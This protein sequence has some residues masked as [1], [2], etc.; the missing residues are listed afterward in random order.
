MTDPSGLAPTRMSADIPGIFDELRRALM[1]YY[2]TPFGVDDVSI[3]KERRSL[4]DTDGGAWRQPL[5]EL[6][7]QYASS[8]VSVEESFRAASAHPQA[9]AFA[10]FALPDGVD[11]LYWH[12]H[13]ALLAAC[14]EGRDFVVTAGTGAGKTEAF[15]LPVIADL[16][17][18]S[19]R[20]TG[21][22]RPAPTW[23]RG[24]GEYMPSRE[25][26]IGHRSAV[27]ALVLYPTNALAD[28]QLVRLRRALD[29]DPARAWLD[30][31]RA[32]HRFYFGR[33]TGATPVPGNR[34]SYPA[35]S[36][37][38][39]YMQALDARQRRAGADAHEFIPRIGGA[40][41]HARWDMQAAAPDILVTNYSMLNIMLLRPQEAPIFES[42]RRWLHST[43]GARF[44]L[45]LD[46][47][48]MYRGTAGTEVAYLLRNLRHRLGLDDAPEKFR[49]L[50]A[51]ASLVGGR[52]DDFLE[53]FFALPR[54]RHK[55]I[56]GSL[57]L[58]AVRPTDL[59]TQAPALARAAESALSAGE[60]GAL[61]SETGAADALALALAPDGKPRAVAM[62]ELAAALFPRL[63]DADAQGKALRG[64]LRALGMAD[65]PALPKLRA[66][67]FFRNIDGIWACSDPECQDVPGGRDPRRRVGRLFREP[68]SRCTCGA[69]VLELLHCQNCGDLMLGG[70]TTPSATEKKRF[71]GA[72]HTDFPDFDLLPEEIS[73]TAN[74]GNY[75]VYWPRQ[76]ALGLNSRDWT[77]SESNNG[78]GVT[79]EFRESRYQPGTGRLAN[80]KAHYTGWSFHVVPDMKDGKP[81]VDLRGLRPFPTRCPACGDDWELKR[82]RDGKWIGLEDP[83]R[84][85][86]APVRR[87]RTGF[88][89]INQVLTTEVLG[90]MPDGGRKIIAFSDS[91]DDASELASGLALRH[92][93]DLLRLLTAQ[94]VTE[95]G[96]PYADLQLVKAFY[97]RDAVD[98]DE[99][100]E[101]VRRLRGRHPREF[102][103][104]K[105]IL[106]DDI[107]A[108]PEKQP[109]LEAVIGNLPS[110]KDLQYDMRGLLLD[111][112]TNPGGPAASLQERGGIAWTSLFNWAG[113]RTIKAGL[114][115]E[116]DE[117]LARIEENLGWEFLNGLF[118]SAGRDFESL[119]LGWLSLVGDRG[120]LDLPTG[121]DEAR[122]RCSLRILGHMRRFSGVRAASEKPPAPLFRYWKHI[123]DRDGLDVDVIA[124]R[125]LAAWG[126][127]VVQYTIDPAKVALRPGDGRVWSCRNC[128][129]SHLHPGTGICT[130]CRTELPAEPERFTGVLNEDY[131]A[132]KARNRTG[133][134]PL[135]T[136]ELTGQTDRLDAQSRQSRFQDVFLGEDDI[137]E[138]DGIEVLSVT[139]T[140]E[141]GVDVGSLNTVLLANMPPTRFNYQQ[142]V[143]RAGRRDSPAATA[144]TVCRGRSHDEHY[145]ARPDEIT[146]A[147]TP[148]PYLALGMPSIFKRVFLGEVLRQAFAALAAGSTD[149]EA[150]MTRN[151]HG[152]FGLSEDWSAHRAAVCQWVDTHQ[153][154]IESAALALQA[155]TP[156]PVASIDPMT[157]IKE[158]LD[159]V[160]KAAEGKTGHPDLSQRLAE[161]GL[162]PMFG[163]P[164]RARLLYTELPQQ[165]FPWPPPGAINRDLAVAL[166]RFAPGA[167]TPRDG[168]LQQS[169]G[170][171]AFTP[172]GRSPKPAE[173]PFGPERMV[174]MCR[175][176][177]HIEPLNE[178]D[179]PT[180]C[181]A[182]GASGRSYT[183]FPFR[184]PAGFRAGKARDYDG[185]REWGGGGLSTRTAA[186]LEKGAPRVDRDADDW[187]VVHCGSGDRYTINNNGGR[188]FRFKKAGSPWKGYY[189]VENPRA[190]PDLETALGATEH[191]DM[192]FL[193]ARAPLDPARGLR[194]DMAK[195]DQLY[196][197]PDAYHGR[198]AAWY[199]LAALL[200]RAAAP[201]LDVQPE[202]LLSGIHGS[203]SS[204]VSPVL[205]YLADS[206]ENGAGF[207]THLGSA[208]RIGEFLGAVDAY[209]QRL[210]GQHAANCSGS[211]YRCLRD[212]SNMRLHPLLDWRLARDLVGALRGRELSVDIAHHELLL[213][214]WTE[215]RTEI[216]V[217]IRHTPVGPMALLTESEVSEEPVA[218]VAKHPLEAAAP[219]CVAPRLQKYA[220]FVEENGLAETVA[221]VD[222]YCLDRTPAAV[223]SELVEYSE[224]L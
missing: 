191:T 180:V 149:E 44:T 60:A 223:T 133:N 5:L 47:L 210:S 72:L 95:Q 70:F 122:A 211:C 197:F 38:R 113:D 91:R 155:S 62:P 23:W 152:Q 153:Q 162:L 182:C 127:A 161:S 220:D 90:H 102:A 156:E 4:L 151:I 219:D 118:S 15:I 51:S 136:A 150:D 217:E 181:P 207:S 111:H 154:K 6:R 108:E 128:R 57:V 85:R 202:E 126:P 88:Y 222:A 177:A 183:A 17:A 114:T 106:T 130:K 173:E 224:D 54:G 179:V 190:V 63:T 164:T 198:R 75:V 142:R 140:M 67:M 186:D 145:F 158:L 192:L 42:T 203:A 41:M 121:S 115:P 134:F 215:D 12:Q 201:M 2:D 18:E 48:H 24:N 68:A 92:Y 65:N 37:L 39:T 74:A 163:F 165:N 61:L 26:E 101:A 112:G 84:L 196:G 11:S 53:S 103:A 66:H 204:A 208:D 194:F 144:L 205:A 93:Q 99:V 81:A 105:D 125:V 159:Q 200:R 83:A 146:N 178:D 184:E 148:P 31:N 104:L 123:A 212:Y 110:L 167:E 14:G 27:R 139:T 166:S 107:A 143:G 3:M 117:F 100:K 175:R 78:P 43:P 109:E 94:A 19:A 80:D 1:R 10:K 129:R 46:E 185:V 221:F 169:I 13:E 45:V 29:S 171:V 28:D 174:A 199:S 64:V 77:A 71:R 214:R 131:Y 58:P 7:P 89:K 79:F 98:R 170:V 32:G 49:V 33:Y 138:A 195:S 189:A 87:M 73:G 35:R 160:D 59:T 69:R 213:R 22:G 25:S 187:L 218:I 55:V 82:T 137:P 40:E 135:R 86:M 172:G 34:D 16:V 119:G 132:W 157:C 116:Q 216:L 176:C 30:R 9:A 56:P 168:R 124:D 97:A 209:L 141:A 52:D 50:A 8:G 20:W 193:G 76:S 188:M 96:D 120:L 206:L 147:P 36:R 21:G